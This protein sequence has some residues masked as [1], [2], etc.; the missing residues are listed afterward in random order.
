MAQLNSRD[1]KDLANALQ[2]LPAELQF[3]GTLTD[4][5]GYLVDEYREVVAELAAIQKELAVTFKE[6]A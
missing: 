3:Q 6:A 1:R 4:E 5:Q 2:I